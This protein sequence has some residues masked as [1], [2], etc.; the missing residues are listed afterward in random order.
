MS[1]L[2]LQFFE[3]LLLFNCLFC[4]LNCLFCV[5]NSFL[6]NNSLK[7]LL[8]ASLAL[9]TIFLER[10]LVNIPDILLDEFFK[11]KI[12]LPGVSFIFELLYCESKLLVD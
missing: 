12:F 10:S 3:L 5:H 6:F 4:V 1:I 2:L 9:A 11:L 8:I 7:F